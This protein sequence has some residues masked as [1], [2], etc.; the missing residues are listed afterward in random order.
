MKVYVVEGD[1][2]EAW[3]DNLTWV[4]GVFASRGAAHQHLIAKGREPVAGAWDFHEGERAPAD[5]WQDAEAGEFCRRRQ[6]MVSEMEVL[7]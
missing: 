7:G 1:N 4:E 3:E 6:Y 2:C 5:L